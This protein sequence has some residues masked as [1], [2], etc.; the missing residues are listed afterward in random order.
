MKTI[1]SICFSCVLAFVI[2]LNA[3]ANG[4]TKR[5]NRYVLSYDGFGPVKIGMKVKQASKAL[6]IPLIAQDPINTNCYFVSA[7][8]NS[9]L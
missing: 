3:S 6:A 9:G 4:Q 2:L 8:R 7:K 5:E 1:K